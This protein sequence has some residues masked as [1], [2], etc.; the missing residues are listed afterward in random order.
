MTYSNRRSIRLKGYD[1]SSPGAYFITINIKNFYCYFGDVSEGVIN[2]SE[3]GKIIDRI[4]NE[5]PI[6]YANAF[7]DEYIIM[8]DHFHGIIWIDR[9]CMGA[10][11]DACT[12]A[13]TDAIMKA[14]TDAIMKASTGGIAGNKNPMLNPLSISNII[15]WFKGRSSYEIRRLP[16]MESFSWHGRFY[17]HIIRDDKSLEKIRRYIINNPV[18]FF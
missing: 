13:C 8:P 2:L 5:I 12:D 1:Y 18:N 10:G 6:R 9:A 4:W 16:D 7:L 11:V 15:R 17:E 14:S 3:S